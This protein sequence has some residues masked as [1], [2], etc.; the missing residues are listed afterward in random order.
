MSRSLQRSKCRRSGCLLCCPWK[1]T[2]E[3]PVAERRATQ[4]DPRELVQDE[5][6]AAIDREVAADPDHVPPG[7]WESLRRAV[8]RLPVLDEGDD[9]ADEEPFI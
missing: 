9:E 4:D 3:R 2:G 8:D 7:Y 1:V 6:R 5:S